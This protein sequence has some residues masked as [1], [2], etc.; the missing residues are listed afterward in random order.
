VTALIV[1]FVILVIVGC[2]AM[3]PEHAVEHAKA[4]AETASKPAAGTPAKPSH[5]IE[6][7]S[8]ARLSRGRLNA[9]RLGAPY[10]R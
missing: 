2:L 1:V 3:A 6:N 9:A 10:K 8:A 5:R 4:T 7:T